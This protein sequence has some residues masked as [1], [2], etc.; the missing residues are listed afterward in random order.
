MADYSALKATIDASINTN[1]QQAITGAILNDVLNEM[2]DVL[3]SGYTFL[4]VATISTNPTT[5]EGKAY[6]LAGAAGTYSNFG[7]IVVNDDE[8]ALLVWNGTAWSKVVTGA[9]SAAEVSQ[10]GQEFARRIA[11][12]DGG[13]YKT[14]VQLSDIGIRRNNYYIN[15]NSG[16]QLELSTSI[17]TN[18]VYLRIGDK[19]TVFTGGAGIA[20]IAKSDTEPNHYT[21][22]TPIQI[23]GGSGL[24]AP[25]VHIVASDGYYSF[26]GHNSSQAHPLEV[27]IEKQEEIEPEDGKIETLE[28]QVE[29]LGDRVENLETEVD[30]IFNGEATTQHY[31]LDDLDGDGALRDYYLHNTIL[32]PR[33]GTDVIIT[34]PIYLHVGDEVECRTGGTGVCLFAKSPSGTIT[35]YTSEFVSIS[36]NT[37]SYNGVISEDG[38]YVFSG[39]INRTDGTNL[40]IAVTAYARGESIYQR[41]DN[42]EEELQNKANISDLE[43][44]SAS[45]GFALSVGAN[46][47]KDDIP[48]APWF[49]DVAND[50]LTYGTYLDDKIDSVPEGDSFIFIT[51]VH[52]AGNRKHSGELLDYVRRRLGIKTMIHGGDVENE[53]P[54]MANAAKQWLDFNRDYP[55]RMGGDFKQV[56]GDHDHNGRYASDGQ[57]FS[58]QF[59]QR[60]MNGYN[61]NELHYDTLYDEQVAQVAEQNN[62]TDYEKKEYDAWK[63]MHYYFDDS[64]IKTRFIVLHTGWTGDVGL[65]V[66][67]LG[68]GALS[69]TNSTYLQMDFLYHSLMTTPNGYNVV[70]VGHNVIGDR[71]YAVEVSGSSVSRYNVNELEWKGSWQQ[72]A[73]MLRAFNGKT[74]TPSLSYRDWTGSGIQTKTFDFT[75]AP[76]A[77]YAF[78][79]G[80][81]VHWDIMGKST[82]SSETL[83]PVAEATSVEHG[84]VTEGTIS[85][86]DILHVLTM[87]DGLDRGYRCIIAPP[88][89]GYNDSTD[90]FLC[91][92]AATTG[93]IDSQAFDI[94]TITDNAIYFTRI[95]AGEDRVIHI[96]NN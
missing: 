74:V 48:A 72:I 37:T 58:Y 13:V 95:G 31:T 94:V 70:V 28:A 18:A 30:E 22:Y 55:L 9:A 11:I 50:G 84:I 38:W 76:T 15:Q 59:V 29:S 7:N 54:I 66:D 56:C 52:Y 41:V 92:P 85:S 6:Y 79:I 62:W 20:V 2:V 45:S 34:N 68:S 14:T 77:H 36:G 64:T 10:L 73:K 42:V 3:G 69:E 1:G 80:G 63:K 81:D 4:G 39:R 40:V 75:N 16:R 12:I 83:L 19:I 43:N 65:A 89:A 96:S 86:S 46:S 21:V 23:T 60:M 88:G 61:I 91:A 71:A 87:A 51:D 26:S 78:C 82:G 27:T 35:Q 49:D 47:V 5:P 57:A 8:V 32:K 53:A 44:I 93:T 25:I 67:K 33:V 24:T 17:I 90:S